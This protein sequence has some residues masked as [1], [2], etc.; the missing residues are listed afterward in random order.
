MEKKSKWRRFGEIVIFFFFSSFSTPSSFFLQIFKLCEMVK[1]WEA[2]KVPPSPRILFF[3]FPF[4]PSYTHSSFFLQILVKWWE[5]TKV[6]HLL[7]SSSYF[8]IS[9]SHLISFLF[10]QVLIFESGLWNCMGSVNM[11]FEL[12]LRKNFTENFFEKIC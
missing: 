6:P 11:S 8:H 2:T 1:W 5:A 7:L 3:F 4:F 12:R 10:S 9:Q